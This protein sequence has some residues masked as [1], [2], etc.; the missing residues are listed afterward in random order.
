ML[1]DDK[2]QKKKIALEVLLSSM[3]IDDNK[4]ARVDALNNILNLNQIQQ[5]NNIA[6]Q[7]KNE[8]ITPQE[9]RELQNV[10]QKIITEV[11]EEIRV[12]FKE[13]DG[14]KN[15]SDAL[16]GDVLALNSLQTMRN[17]LNDQIIA[18]N[19]K[20]FEEQFP[21]VPKEAPKDEQ[22]EFAKKFP[23]VPQDNL[24]HQA[25]STTSTKKHVD[26]RKSTSP[27]LAAHIKR[28]DNFLNRLQHMVMKANGKVRYKHHVEWLK[29][30][31]NQLKNQTKDPSILN[32]LDL[33]NKQA[34]KLLTPPQVSNKL[35][36]TT[37]QHIKKGRGRSNTL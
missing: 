34:S 15:Q 7:A 20:R 19:Q 10:L 33:L 26:I 5:L 27:S 24:S 14:D 18:I 3:N 32:R 13:N 11:D 12:K 35:E 16:K 36:K 1:H 8:D 6:Q 21:Q 23:R 22:A 28:V 4:T 9:L 2:N 25:E 30:Y 37:M 17:K 31:I 29:R